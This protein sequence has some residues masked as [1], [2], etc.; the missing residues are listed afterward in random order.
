MSTE[1][2]GTYEKI[3]FALWELG[4]R[5]GNF[6]QFRVIGRSHDDRMIPMLEIGKGDTC[7]ICLSGV[8]SGDRNLPEY[9][10]SIAKDYCRSYESNWTIG[11]SYEVRKLL[12]KV[13][14][15]MIPMLNPDSYEICE[16]GYG[17]IHNPIHRQMLKMQDR[18]VEEYECNARG[19]D[20]RRNFPTNYY[21]RKRVN[22]EPASENETRALISIFQE[23]SSL[24]LLTF[25]YSRGKIV[26]CRQEKGF[27]YNQKNYRLARHLQKCSGYR[28]EKGIAAQVAIFGEGMNEAWK[29][30]HINRRLA[31]NCFGDY[32]PRT[33]LD[34]KQREMITFCFLSA[35]GGCELQLTAHAKGNLNLGNDKAFLTRV[36]LQCLPYLGY[37]RSLNAIACINK[38]AEGVVLLDEKK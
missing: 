33:G 38:A 9:L 34:L 25:S 23:Y 28:L 30:S 16:Y 32:Y 22:Q 13:R 2:M 36:V 37:P 15:C 17:A 8:E 20:L 31:D 24:G 14:I 19:I 29:K 11:E 18:P 21:H 26:Y 1:Q 10:L 3:Y 5:Y 7:I 12:D 4:Q 27:A 35:Q 6:V